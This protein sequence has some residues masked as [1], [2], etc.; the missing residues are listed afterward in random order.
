MQLGTIE[1]RDY[2][3][4]E[5]LWLPIAWMNNERSQKLMTGKFPA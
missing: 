4:N 5:L 1:T 2:L 3:Q